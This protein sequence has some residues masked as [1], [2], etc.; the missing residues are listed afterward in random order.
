MR[1]YTCLVGDLFHAGH[2][3]FLKQ[4]KELGD[5]LIVGVCSDEDC[6]KYKRKPVMNYSERFTVIESCKYVDE[7]VGKPPSILNEEFIE[8][9]KIDLVVHGDDSTEEQLWHFYKAAIT[10]NK[11]K[12]IKYTP[13]VSTSQ[14]IERIKDRSVESLNRKN[15]LS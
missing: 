10:Q 8:M 1:I 11:Y 4:A 12:S 13:N 7:I 6:E 9:H 2:V 3:N 5:Y 14:I 15:G